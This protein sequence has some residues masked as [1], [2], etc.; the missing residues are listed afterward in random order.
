MLE[1]QN[2]QQL[3]VK[4]IKACKERGIFPPE[5]LD[6]VE[7]IY[8]RQLE[9]RLE[10]EVPDAATLQTAD[11]LQ[12]SQGAPLLERDSFP[13]D[14]KQAQALFDEFLELTAACS[15]ALSEGAKALVEARNQGKLDLDQAMQAHLKGD[16]AFFNA[17]ADTTPMAPR[18]LPMLVQAAMTPS[19]ERVALELSAKTDLS[20]SW[21]HGHC[22][23][24]GSM[25]I[26]SD[27]RE[28]EGFRYNICGFCHAEYH[29][30]RLQ[31]P[32]CLEK[33]TAK[34]EYYEA[35]EE[36]GV[37]INACRTCMMYIKQT[38]FRNLDR[39]SLPLI[40]D[41]DSLALDIAAREKD[42]K[43]PSLSAWGF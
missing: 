15:P 40:D 37:R 43:R 13:F 3:L 42:F 7:K 12:H 6:L 14:R 10:A 35:K 18:I 5:L 27:L 39:R 33:D 32:F 11:A 34:L 30:P 8:S 2:A 1:A 24:C 22:P 31:C 21:P 19:L 28:K 29:S 20:H 38:D 9:A 4:K 36:P 17:W 25:P 23:V 41:L 16:E 26:M